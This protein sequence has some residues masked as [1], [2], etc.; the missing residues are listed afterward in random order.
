MKLEKNKCASE[1]V[2]LIN[3]PE[4]SFIENCVIG[5]Y[6]LHTNT[7]KI[8]SGLPILKTVLLKRS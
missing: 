2:Y 4:D 5:Y 8:N 6:S 3:V 1:I 7:T